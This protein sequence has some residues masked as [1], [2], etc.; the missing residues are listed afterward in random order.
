MSTDRIVIIGGGACGAKVAARARRNSSNAEI[1]IIDKGSSISYAGC[2]MP[3]YI[4]GAVE[5]ASDLM[6]MLWGTV[7]DEKY[8]KNSKNV[9]VYTNTT[10]ETIEPSAKSIKIIDASGTTRQLTYSKLVLATGAKAKVPSIDGINLKNVFVLRSLE[11]AREI[12]EAIE[13]GGVE[14]AVIVGAGRVGLE[15][16]DAF[17]AQGLDI[18][19]VEMADQVLP[20]VL[21]SDMAQYPV[22][23]LRSEKI[24]LFM[25][26]SALRLLGDQNNRVKKVITNRRELDADM[27]IFAVGIKPDIGLAKSAGIKIGETG[28]IAVDEYMQT[29][30]PDIYAGGDCVECKDIITGKAVNM[31]LGSVANKQGRVIANTITGMSDTFPGV[32]GSSILMSLG[33]K[34]G[35]T[36]LTEKHAKSLGYET[37]AC[38]SVTR[39]ISHFLA[40][41]RNIVTK[42]IVSSKDRR[43]LGAQIVGTGDVAKR[44]DVAVTSVSFKAKIDDIAALDL[45]YA[46]PFATA[47]DSII[48]SANIMRN[49]LSGHV[50]TISPDAVKQKLG[51]KE[52]FILLDLRTGDEIN[53]GQKVD[54][55]RVV[56]IPLEQLRGR[57][58]ELPKDKEI[59]CTCQYGTRAYEAYTILQG[60]G[61]ERT[62]YVECGMFGYT[63]LSS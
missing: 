30:I 48:H 17:N 24:N 13:S 27:V 9:T 12:R 35:K 15:L 14:K 18:T 49:K 34:I 46:P 23:I 42:L 31:P 10:V 44:L 2:G 53:K 62:K 16:A 19:I 60:N 52:D 22:N 41:S 51:S 57:V 25:Q 4:A 11:N 28:A 63:W 33:L 59:V 39:D 47:M 40:G 32:A 6:S 29:N 58:T 5:H 54:D 45:C 1:I 61:F 3:Y 36:G 55:K 43:L 26:E 8:F 20:D 37:E 21:D 38:L 50:K 7:R 56:F